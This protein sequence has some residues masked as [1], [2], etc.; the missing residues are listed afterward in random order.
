[1][2]AHVVNRRIGSTNIAWCGAVVVTLKV[3]FWVEEPL[4]CTDETEHDASNMEAGTAQEK[5]TVPANPLMGAIAIVLVA[6]PPRETT[7][8]P[9]ALVAIE[10]SRT[11]MLVADDV[12]EAWLASPP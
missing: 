2:P 4:S 5:F 6:E 8:F 3:A 12:A 10:K 7:R 11:T 9:L 1:M